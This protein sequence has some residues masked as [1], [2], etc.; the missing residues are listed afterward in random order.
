MTVY[1]M[2]YLQPNYVNLIFHNYYRLVG[3]NFTSVLL[4]AFVLTNN[5]I[6]AHILR[7]L[8]DEMPAALECESIKDI[9]PGALAELLC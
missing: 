9:T 8:E 4:S 2:I 7:Y 5:S 6:Q 3:E 1:Q